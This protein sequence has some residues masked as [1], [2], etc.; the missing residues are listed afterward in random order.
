MSKSQ[1]KGYICRPY[2]VFFREGQK[3]A[4]ACQGAQVVER[5]VAQ[6]R[7]KPEALARHQKHPPLW[8]R[9]DATLDASICQHCS[10]RLKDCDFTS[11]NP[12]PDCEPCGGYIL[13]SL[14]MAKG[15]LTS[16]DLKEVALE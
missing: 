10:F 13:V 3:E 7:L 16:D 11:E 1:F 5:L 6:G 2:C 14:L 8:Q 9:Q 15:M 4:M 12:P